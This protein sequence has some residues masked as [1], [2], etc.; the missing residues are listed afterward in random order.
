[1]ESVMESVIRVCMRSSVIILPF[2]LLGLYSTTGDVIFIYGVIGY[3]IL[4]YVEKSMKAIALRVLPADIA[5]RPKG[6]GKNKGCSVIEL[7][8][9][10]GITELKS[11]FPSGHSLLTWY[12][13]AFMGWY[14]NS[15]RV[16]YKN[17]I[18]VGLVS[19]GVG[20]S[21]SRVVL[22]NCHTSLQVMVGSVLGVVCGC[23]MGVLGTKLNRV[24]G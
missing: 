17:S 1:M 7:D 21:Y 3:M 2:I 19:Y 12:F 11:G 10:S 16:R 15:R 23:M 4:I 6:A 20:M 24:E 22:E 14:V 5:L 8:E 18:I 13:V 9:P